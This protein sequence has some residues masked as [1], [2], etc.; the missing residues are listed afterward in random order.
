MTTKWG[1]VSVATLLLSCAGLAQASPIML[2]DTTYFT[3]T[4]TNSPEDYVG[5]GRGDVNKLD[6]ILD[7]VKW[8][9]Q[10]TFDPAVDHLVSGKLT[11]HLRDDSDSIWDGLEIGFGYAENGD[12]D[13]G[14]VNTGAYQYDVGISSLADGAFQVKIASLWGDFYIKK[15]ILEIK[16]VA[17][18]VPEPGTVFLLGTGLLG[19]ALSRR[20]RHSV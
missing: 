7:Y 9:H 4:G 5:H 19:L 20:R 18:S 11:L 12:W 14:E 15:S 8:K 2:T 3:A 6:G 17:V 13:I 10:Y 16:Y 1:L